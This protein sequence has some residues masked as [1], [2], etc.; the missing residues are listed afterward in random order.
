MRYLATIEGVEREFEIDELE[1]G[2]RRLRIDGEEFML[3]L[4]RI[5]PASFSILAGER[6]FSLEVARDGADILVIGRDFTSRLRVI[7]PRRAAQRLH[8]GRGEAA[9]RA[10]IRAMMP[11]RIV[12]VLANPG[13][14]IELGQGLLVVEAMKME[15]EIKAPKSGVVSEIR[16]AK[17]ST[18]EKNELLAIIE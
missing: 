1:G 17:G 2:V 7:D 10:E 15:N 14:H 8:A 16:V 9:G 6:S 5:G 11:G 4:R 13:D 18:V 3:D 12:N